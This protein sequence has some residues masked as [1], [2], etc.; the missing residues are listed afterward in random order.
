MKRKI[1]L[2]IL[3]IVLLFNTIYVTP[4]HKVYAAAGAL[5]AQGGGQKIGQGLLYL[6]GIAVAAGAGALGLIEN[7]EAMQEAAKEVAETASGWASNTWDW[8]KSKTITPDDISNIPPDQLEKMKNL[9]LAV[10][11]GYISSNMGKQWAESLPKTETNITGRDLELTPEEAAQ[12][13]YEVDAMLNTAHHIYDSGGTAEGTIK[14]KDNSVFLLTLSNGKYIVANYVSGYASN[15]SFVWKSSLSLPGVDYWNPYFANRNYMSRAYID[16]PYTALYGKSLL[17][18]LYTAEN[19]ER[20]FSKKNYK[21]ENSDTRILSVAI[22]SLEQAAQVINSASAYSEAWERVKDAGMVVP[23]TMPIPVRP[24]VKATDEPLSWQGDLVIDGTLKGGWT[25]KKGDIVWDGSMD[26]PTGLVWDFPTPHVTTDS[27][28]NPVISVP[29]VMNP[30]IDWDIP[31]SNQGTK[32]IPIDISVPWTNIVTGKETDVPES[33][34]PTKVPPGYV[35]WRKLRNIPVA[36]TEKF[37]FSLPFDLFYLIDLLDVPP[38]RIEFHG[39]FTVS[40]MEIPLDIEVSEKW[41]NLAKILRF[42]TFLMFAI[43]L[44]FA[45][46]NLLGGGV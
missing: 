43:G 1:F 8:I 39:T 20:Y 33:D 2:S 23:D 9:S 36:F 37:P 40:K 35:N 44:I 45:T 30:A 4:K 25:T 17:S 13:F 3:S 26:L 42:S 15:T 38:E 11:T 41:D 32:D 46:R 29:D 6:T 28:G 10:S 21:L 27:V 7:R 22:V 14:L 16:I 5:P 18:K 34:V 12:L 19:V 31:W 24:K